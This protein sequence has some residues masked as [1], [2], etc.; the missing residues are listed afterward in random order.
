M[1]A[2][3][4][5]IGNL[6]YR[7][8]LGDGHQRIESV[9]ELSKKLIT[10]GPAKV[11]CNYNEIDPIPLTEKWLLKFGFEKHDS[12]DYFID[13]SNIGDIHSWFS[14]F[15]GDSFFYISEFDVK[16]KYVHQLQN[17]FFALCGEEL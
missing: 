6:I 13:I 8:D 2:T 17:L 10:S 15:K 4:L 12:H 1:K 14:V 3:E 7:N 11:I 9:L 5:R 16:I